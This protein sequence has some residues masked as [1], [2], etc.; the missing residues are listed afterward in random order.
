MHL[1][2]LSS[3]HNSNASKKMSALFNTRKSGSSDLAKTTEHNSSEGRTLQER[4]FHSVDS[5]SDVDISDGEETSDQRAP[6]IFIG[7]ICV[8]HYLANLNLFRLCLKICIGKIPMY[9]S[10]DTLME[11]LQAIIPP[12]CLTRDSQ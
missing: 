10:K 8:E 3:S 9:L 6:I 7:I 4:D 5:D 1:N 12:W 11:K 2:F